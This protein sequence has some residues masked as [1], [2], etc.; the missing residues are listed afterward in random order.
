MSCPTRTA[1]ERLHALQTQLYPAVLHSASRAW[2]KVNTDPLR[3]HDAAPLHVTL[4]GGAG[5]IAYSLAF[6]IARGQMLGLY[7]PVVLRLLDLP[8]PEK[9]RAQ[10]A[11]VMEL[12][13][14][15]FGLLR[16]VVATADPREAFAGAHVVVLVGS[17]PRAAGQLRRD[18]LA[19]NAAIFKAQ[20]KAVSDYADPDVRVLVVANPANTNCLVFSRC[21][22][23]IPRT[24]VS[25]M[26]R[27][28]HNRSK[29][30][31]AERV[32]VETRNVHNAI[33]WGNHSGTQYPDLRFAR[34]DDFPTKGASTPARALINDDEWVFKTF[35]PTV[36][37]RGYKVIEARKLS[38]AASA[39]TAACDAIRDW[40]LGTPAGEMVSMGVVTDGSK[41]GI[42]EDLVFSMPVQCSGGEYTVVDNLPVDA[43][44][45][46]RLR[47]SEQELIAERT[48][49][50]TLLGLGK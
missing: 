12:K 4:T 29:A 33:V 41:Y 20:G 45:Q 23:N 10:E 11:V 17:S 50:Y 16:D 48:E 2:P 18:L 30:Q 32:G 5:Q 49:A 6:L 15:A 1:A 9:Q 35:V 26:T 19:Q 42:A 7:Q 34:V 46:R 13:D 39:A 22:P 37:Q 3:T 24:H 40:V 27:L 31:I 44:S 8:R 14:C 43:E 21:A 38:S 47:A 36:Q 25:C 28:D